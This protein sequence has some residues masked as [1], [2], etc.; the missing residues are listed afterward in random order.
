MTSNVSGVMPARV[1]SERL[2]SDAIVWLRS[3]KPGIV[4]PAAV[5]SGF[6]ARTPLM[7]TN[8]MCISTPLANGQRGTPMR[9]ARRSSV[10]AMAWVDVTGTSPRGARGFG[11]GA[12]YSC[13][14]NAQ[15]AALSRTTAKM[16]MMPNSW[17]TVMTWPKTE[18]PR[19]GWPPRKIWR[20]ASTP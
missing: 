4:S 7:A 2:G 18:T 15:T 6:Q 12:F 19:P 9:C 16:E 8:A 17:G 20:M 5:I 14:P 1:S 13:L 3:R 11:L 10:D